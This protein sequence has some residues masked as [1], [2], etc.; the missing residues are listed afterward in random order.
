[1]NI[2]GLGAVKQTTN[3]PAVIDKVMNKTAAT[4]FIFRDLMN[5]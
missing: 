2:L 1:L 3:T 5:E 4:T